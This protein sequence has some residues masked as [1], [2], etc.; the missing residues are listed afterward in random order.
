MSAT[1]PASTSTR[2]SS[3]GELHYVVVGHPVALG[4]GGEDPRRLQPVRTRAHEPAASPRHMHVDWRVGSGDV[5]RNAQPKTLRRCHPTPGRGR[6]AVGDQLEAT[7]V[8]EQRGGRIDPPEA[9]RFFDN[10]GVGGSWSARAGAPR[11]QPHASGRGVVVLDR[12]DI[13]PRYDVAR[14]GPAAHTNASSQQ[15]SRS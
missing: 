7:V 15:P 6:E 14:M 4:D 8:V 11:A 5:S 3:D 2:R 13:K 12:S 9:D 10:V 1:C